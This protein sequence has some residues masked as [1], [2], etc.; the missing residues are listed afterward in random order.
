MLR[1][2]SR[3]NGYGATTL[4]LEGRLVG[5]WVEELRRACGET[6]DP[7][8]LV[9]DLRAVSFVDRDGADLLRNLSE[10][11]AEITNCSPFVAEQLRVAER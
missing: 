9:L 8:S 1:I 6:L 3:C 2:V 4:I 7:A 10:R 5:P 11:R